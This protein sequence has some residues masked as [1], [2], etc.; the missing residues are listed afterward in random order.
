MYALDHRTVVMSATLGGGLGER[1]AALMPACPLDSDAHLVADTP[2][3]LPASAPLLVSQGR[4]FPVK[5]HYLGLPGAG[6]AASDPL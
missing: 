6:N 3:G 2:A 4:S 5:T 1:V